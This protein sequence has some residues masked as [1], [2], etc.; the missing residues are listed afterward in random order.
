MGRKSKAE[1]LGLVERIIS[2]YGQNKT[3]TE[4]EKILRA[5]G[6]DISRE[7]IR[8]SAK[9]SAEAAKKYKIVYQEAQ[10]IVDT[11]RNNPG[12]DALEAITA[13]ISS[14][15]LEEVKNID[16]MDFESPES[17]AKVESSLS[18]SQVRIAKIRLEHSKGYEAAKKDFISRLSEELKDNHPQLLKQLVEIVKNMSAKNE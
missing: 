10:A 7:A 11:I 14:K 18:N 13:V 9:S 16:G 1:L 8:K 3:Y 17:L 15:L 5:D 12:T 6:Y 2:L 4:I